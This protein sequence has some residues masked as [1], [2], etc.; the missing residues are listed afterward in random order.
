MKRLAGTILVLATLPLWGAAAAA[1]AVA[2]L[3]ADGRPV[4]FSQMRAGLGGRPFRLWKFRTMREGE[5]G[6][7]ERTTRLGR[8]L[9]A[10]SL[11]ELPQLVQVLTGK[12]ALVGPRP[13]PVRYLPRYSPTEARRHD[14][15]PGVTGFAQVNGRNAISWRRK[16][17]LDVWYARN[18][19][20]AL[21]A[22]ILLLTLWKVV[23][24][25]GVDSSAGETMEEFRGGGVYKEGATSA[26]IAASP[27][28]LRR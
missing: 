11:D 25:S 13:L 12:M 16:F 26:D 18:R 7:M 5:G 1:V 24:R 22:K 14:V 3:L 21:D 15:R 9:R 28:T 27:A 6:D 19:S 23:R 10:A 8:I 20:L 17:A 2:V 4:L